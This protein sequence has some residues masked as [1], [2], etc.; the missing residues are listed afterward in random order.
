MYGAGIKARSWFA[1]RFLCFF[2]NED[3]VEKLRELALDAVPVQPGQSWIP[4][5][6]TA[7]LNDNPMP[8]RPASLED[9]LEEM[10]TEP[11]YRDQLGEGSVHIEDARA[12]IFEPLDY[13]LS[14]QL[15]TAIRE[16]TGITQLYTHQARAINLVE[17]GHHVVVSTSTSR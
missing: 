4:D 13:S 12:P 5:A 7:E 11:F 6:T 16:S 3:P 17:K 14:P 9:L 1:K 10:K 2:Q 15:S 8:A